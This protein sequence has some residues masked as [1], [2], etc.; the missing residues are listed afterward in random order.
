VDG[1]GEAKRGRSDRVAG[2]PFMAVAEQRCMGDEPQQAGPSGGKMATDKWP[3]CQIFSKM[4]IKHLKLN[5]P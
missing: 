5:S 3:P 2:L 1:D 4:K